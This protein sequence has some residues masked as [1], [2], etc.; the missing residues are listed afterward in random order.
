M[1]NDDQDLQ[2]L[3][4]TAQNQLQIT[5]ND[6]DSSDSKGLAISGI[7]LA[8]GIYVLQ[9][10]MSSPWWILAPLFVA[11]LVSL[12]CSLAINMPRAYRGAHVSL[13]EHP[14][15]LEMSRSD[16]TLQLLAN[17]QASIDYN[18]ALNKL[19]TR[20]SL[21]ALSTTLLATGLLVCCII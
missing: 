17:T 1:V 15:Y 11:L 10:E 12:L 21:V 5:L 8:L 6:S 13:E 3:L 20:L 7:D 19:K 14:E 2:P 4:D 18:N 9:S 16:L